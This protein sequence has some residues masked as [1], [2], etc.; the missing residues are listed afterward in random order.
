MLLARQAARCSLAR[1]IPTLAHSFT[2]SSRILAPTRPARP[3]A[4]AAAA[5]ARPRQQQRPQHRQNGKDFTD[6]YHLA[7][8]IKLL[9]Q[10][11]QLDAALDLVK[12]SPAYAANIV[13]WNV[14]LNSLLRAQKYKMAYNTWM[15]MKRRGLHPTAR[16][17]GTFFSGFAK[18]R[19]E[20]EG[21][22]LARVKTV[23][24]QWLVHAERTMEKADLKERGAVRRSIME[25]EHEQEV[26][27]DSLDDITV[28][29]TNHYLSFL[30]HTGNIPLLLETFQAMPSDGPLAP[31]SLTYSIVLAG[32]RTSSSTNP[33]HFAAALQLWER[34]VK[35]AGEMEIDTK[36]VSIIISICREAKRP[37]DQR[38]GLQVA[39][40]FYGLVDPA[41]E[42]KLVDPKAL[43]PPRVAMDSAALSNVFALALA[44]QQFNLVVRWFDQVRDYPKRFGA[45]LIEH[46]QCDLVLVALAAKHDAA[47]AEDLINWMRR[48]AP[49]SSLQP[50]LASYSNAIQVCWRSADLVRAYRLLSLMTARPIGPE[51]VASTSTTTI[52]STAADEPSPLPMHPPSPSTLTCKTF[53][54]D[55]RILSTLLQ[56]S[57]AT[58]DRGN[59]Y[60]ALS[61]VEGEFGRTASYYSPCSRAAAEENDEDSDPSSHASFQLRSQRRAERNDPFHAYWKFKLG[62]V[63]ERC[64]E[65]V[66]QGGEGHLTSSRRSELV[67]WRK[68]VVAWLEEQDEKSLR[69]KGG[70]KEEENMRSRREVLREK[71]EA[72]GRRHEVKR[73]ENE[74]EQ[75]EVVDPW[76]SDEP[77]RSATRFRKRDTVRSPYDDRPPPPRRSFSPSNFRQDRPPRRD[78][79]DSDRPPPR[80]FDSDRPP[81]R[82]FDSDQPPRR[83]AFDSD[84][85]PPRRASFDGGRPSFDRPPPRRSLDND[86]DR[87]F[88]PRSRN[89]FSSGSGGGGGGGGGARRQA[90]WD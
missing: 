10:R 54:P 67:E 75:R 71:E 24:A 57:L 72:R 19:G 4:A 47:G 8:R 78:Y 53:A 40:D 6:S 5:A 16:S 35:D 63:L 51:A 48:S 52:D 74:R 82:R 20:V 89:S 2:S 17:F 55:D 3:A 46:H 32:L 70:V 88:S 59:I 85:P 18:M 37:D 58:R 66:L 44:M 22:S 61:I 69:G 77:M 14:L 34:I 25:E 87:S 81:P 64:L 38:L 36:T 56:T 1:P 90:S 27:I 43:P 13:V 30:S 12:S 76:R 23:Y 11:D 68:G 83:P 65:R 9:A 42:D 80:R 86:D 50:T 31:T 26:L 84:R 39:K 62:E 33:E 15:D 29:P 28:I 41:E 73:R 7:D 79:D 21:A 45:G 60:R 49:S